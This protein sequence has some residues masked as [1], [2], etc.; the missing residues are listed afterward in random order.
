MSAQGS[1][2]HTPFLGG[3]DRHA[4]AWAVAGSILLLVAFAET[5][6][7]TTVLIHEVRTGIA[8]L[9]TRTSTSPSRSDGGGL[10]NQSESRGMAALASPPTLALV[11]GPSLAAVPMLLTRPDGEDRPPYLDAIG[12]GISW[13][14]SGAPPIV[15][16]AVVDSGVDVT[17]PDL[18][19]HLWENP[20]WQA[21]TSNVIKDDA[22]GC[23]AAR[24]GCA[25]VSPETAAGSCG[26]GL[27]RPSSEIMDDNG[28]GTFVA[29]LVMAAAN[30]VAGGTTEG[31]HV[32]I[33]PVKVLDCAGDGRAS[34]AAAGIRY[35]ARSG[36]QVIVLA[37]SG[38]SDVPALRDAVAEA[39]R[40]YGAVVVAAAGN[41]SGVATHFPS[42]YPDVLG[43]GGTGVA[44]A[45]ESQV[46]YQR[47]APF[48]NL[49]DSVRL[50]APAVAIKGPVPRALCGQ[51]DWACTSGDPYAYAS[52]TSYA[53]PLVAGVLAALLAYDPSLTPDEA[54]RLLVDTA[55][56]V[57]GSAV[58][59]VD[60]S[61][62][63]ARAQSRRAGDDAGWLA[64]GEG[65][66]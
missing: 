20:Q 40:T 42:G 37:F 36:A 9:R 7:F 64:S 18:V 29:G 19:G 5:R 45:D 55:T 6:E 16:V 58:G 22:A 3:L 15:T 23:A 25:F 14:H 27:D 46:D 2:R 30:T 10:E 48:S 12:A 31:V 62:A 57:H 44:S 4:A 32:R 1:L 38:T 65:I 33:L 41:D 47:L 13:V 53:T 50:L 49:S 39:R 60:I 63:L 56:P 11:T 35:A 54:T 26:Y 51:R 52:G 8:E 61:A 34:Q 28:H 21:E 24:H 17:H 59:Q 66:E 43:V